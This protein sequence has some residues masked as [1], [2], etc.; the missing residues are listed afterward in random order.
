MS[1]AVR[2]RG[3]PRVGQQRELE[4]SARIVDDMHR[5]VG[6]VDARIDGDAADQRNPHRQGPAQRA[7]VR[8]RRA[9]APDRCRGMAGDH[10]HTRIA[11][12]RA[13][14]IEAGLDA[15]CRAVATERRRLEDALLLVP[16]RDALAM[17]HDARSETRA[18]DAPADA[19]SKLT[20]L[21]D[22]GSANYLGEGHG[23]DL[24]MARHRSIPATCGSIFADDGRDF[25]FRAEKAVLSTNTIRTPPSHR[26]IWP[27]RQ[28]CKPRP[29]RSQ[30]A[31][32]TAVY[33]TPGHVRSTQ[34]RRVRRQEWPPAKRARSSAG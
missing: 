28:D 1:S 24:D 13:R 33:L 21:G 5:H 8:M 7:V 22:G 23:R 16:D 11:H 34:A 14:R 9:D 18:R 31:R 17:P 6:V 25:P 4:P 27:A 32:I 10:R 20:N 12:M 3:I 15:R 30:A 19:I 2:P 29:P 26:P